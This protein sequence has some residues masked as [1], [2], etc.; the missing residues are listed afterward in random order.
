MNETR[1]ILKKYALDPYRYIIK[2]NVRI[3]DTDKGRFVLK[4]RKEPDSINIYRY[5]LSRDFHNILEE[6]NNDRDD[7][8][9]TPYI[10][11]IETPDEQKA[12]DLALL[13]GILHAKTVFYK[14]IDLDKI[15]EI[16]ESLTLKINSTKYY[17][18]TLEDIIINDIYM[19]PSCY[20]LIR[21]ISLI[22]NSLNYALQELE[23]WYDIIS[24]RKR[25]RVVVVHNNLLTEHLLQ[26]DNDYLISWDK[27]KLDSP[28]YDFYYF[29]MNND[30]TYDYL[31]LFELYE[32]K[33]PLMIE[34]KKLLYVLLS[35]PERISIT[36]NIFRDT[37]VIYHLI[38]R[39]QKGSEIISKH[40]AKNEPKPKQ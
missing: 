1:E 16:Y 13:M 19:A 11:N 27:A 40:Y 20:L 9:I 2:N 15:K 29:F 31:T 6:Y 25:E 35:I 34:E 3:V 30:Y 4:R 36:Y 23:E 26:G 8:Y 21:N 22:Y 10:D 14:E 33:F 37:K 38:Y 24:E 18:Q 28:I 5:L 32:S 17:Y 12:D 39:L 7:Y